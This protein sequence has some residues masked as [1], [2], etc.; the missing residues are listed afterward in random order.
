LSSLIVMG[1]VDKGI[2]N[3]RRRCFAWTRTGLPAFLCRIDPVASAGISQDQR[4]KSFLG[5]SQLNNYMELKKMHWLPWK[6]GRLN[7][8]FIASYCYCFHQFQSNSD[9]SHYSKFIANI[10]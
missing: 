5:C 1:R 2:I 4:G 8:L 10:C 7:V 3:V 9:S 6:D